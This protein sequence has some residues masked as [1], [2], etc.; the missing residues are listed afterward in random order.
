MISTPA[1]P[2]IAD[3]NT[4]FWSDLISVFILFVWIIFVFKKKKKLWFAAVL[5]KRV[6]GRV[7]LNEFD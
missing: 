7:W 6:G 2:P 1:F 5:K 4:V 3:A